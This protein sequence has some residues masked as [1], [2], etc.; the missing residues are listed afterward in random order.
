MWL[1]QSEDGADQDSPEEGTPASPRNKRRVGRPG[2]KRKQMLPVSPAVADWCQSFPQTFLTP[3]CPSGSP[4]TYPCTCSLPCGKQTLA[5]ISN[6]DNAG[7]VCFEIWYNELHPPVSGYVC[8]FLFESFWELLF[9]LCSQYVTAY[10]KCWITMI[11][12]IFV[13]CLGFFTWCMFFSSCMHTHS[14]HDQCSK[15]NWI[16]KCSCCIF[17][18]ILSVSVI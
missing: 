18:H 16:N 11:R 6:H 12:G 15:D 10:S 4:G 14:I 8:F 3:S 13:A 1:A 17:G 2:R 5:Q 7:W 9:A